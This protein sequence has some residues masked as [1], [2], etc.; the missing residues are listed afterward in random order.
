MNYRTNILE[1]MI[2]HGDIGLVAVLQRAW[3]LMHRFVRCLQHVG[4][5]DFTSQEQYDQWTELT[6]S[7]IL[8]RLRPA[9]QEDWES[10]WESD[11]EGFSNA[12]G[13]DAD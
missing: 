4:Y 3:E 5:G 2:H 7:E 13:S 1:I 10:D 6:E 11:W 12:R 9:S 8:D